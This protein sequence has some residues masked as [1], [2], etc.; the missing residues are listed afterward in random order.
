MEPDHPL[1]VVVGGLR[2]ELVA[3]ESALSVRAA[4]VAAREAAPATR[5]TYASVYRAFAAALGPDATAADVTPQAVRAW[6]DRLEL[7][8]RSPSIR[9]LPVPRSGG[10]LRVAL[11]GDALRG[12]ADKLEG[13]LLLVEVLLQQGGDLLGAA[14]VRVVDEDLVGG[15]LHVLGLDRSA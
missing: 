14:G 9:L 1:R 8:G 4:D 13:V 10:G 3:P 11:A 15:D 5:S 12:L 7:E 6:R 2:G